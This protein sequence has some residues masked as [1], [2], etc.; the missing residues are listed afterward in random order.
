MFS[1]SV[2]LIGCSSRLDVFQMPCRTQ[3]CGR[4]QQ[5]ETTMKFIAS[6][7]LIFVIY[8]CSTGL[9]Y[10]IPGDFDYPNNEIKAGKTFVYKNSDSNQY[11]FK[12]IK[13]INYKGYRSIKSYDEH[14][15]KDSIITYNGRT[16]EV[17]NFF[18]L[19][20]GKAIRGQ[21]LQD[22]I[23]NNN[24]K[25]G[26]HLTEWS[27]RNPKVFLTTTLEEKYNKDTTVNWQNHSLECLVTQ[28]NGILRYSSNHQTIYTF[29]YYYAKGIGLIKYASEYTDYHGKYYHTIWNLLSIKDIQ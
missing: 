2:S 16:I 5:Y 13:L 8:S 18:I 21:K 25:L 6:L 1:T 27:Y 28:A 26:K 3:S 11:Y 15:I 17:Y 10:F 29:K 12:D 19:G 23:L 9:T 20:N 4:W 22:I 24:D 14:S 7:F